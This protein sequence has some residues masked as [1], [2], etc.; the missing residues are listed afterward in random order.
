M[1]HRVLVV[2]DD[3]A[4]RGLLGEVLRDEGYEVLEAADGAEG[5]ALV[6]ARRPDLVIMDLRMPLMNGI[7]AIK[8]L[9]A[10]PA[11]AGLAI[12]AMSAGTVL[13]AEATQLPVNGL[14]DKPFDLDALL[15]HVALSLNQLS[16]LR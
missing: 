15:A 1:V 16:P 6:R 13:R 3:A 4:I 11:L 9:R 10:D 12:L 5:V 7:E 8:A 14:I 2:D